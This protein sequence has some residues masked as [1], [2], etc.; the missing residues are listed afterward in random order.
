MGRDEMIDQD[1][2]DL[3]TPTGL[4]LGFQVTLFKWRIER[5]VGI[6]D[7]VSSYL[8][9]SDYV[10]IGGMLCFL[11]G[12]ILLPSAGVI[13]FPVSRVTFGLGL[14][15]FIGQHLSLAGHYELYTRK[16]REFEWFPRQEKITVAFTL[17][18]ALFYI[19]IEFFPLLNKQ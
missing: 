19:L 7:K 18:M 5:E 8:V 15:F 3:W 12:V 6:G 9:P 13:A 17:L 10:G 16:P 4:L 11:F 2:K 1:L 14:L